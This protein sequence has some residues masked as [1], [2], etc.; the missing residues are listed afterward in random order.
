MKK[1]LI[2]IIFITA[3]LFADYTKVTP[4]IG[5]VPIMD[6]PFLAEKYYEHYSSSKGFHNYRV[7]IDSR[8]SYLKRDFFAKA[9]GVLGEENIIRVRKVSDNVETIQVSFYN[10]E[11]RQGGKG[12][13]HVSAVHQ[14]L[15]EEAAESKAPEIKKDPIVKIPLKKAIFDKFKL[16]YNIVTK[17]DLEDFFNED[18]PGFKEEIARIKASKSNPEDKA[19]IKK[20]STNL[21]DLQIELDETKENLESKAAKLETAEEE[22][23]SFEEEQ[24]KEKIKSMAIAGAVALIIGLVIGFSLKKS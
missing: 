14:K 2:S 3:S 9:L 12:F 10:T 21:E 13:V 19:K 1:L 16:E 6:S 23:K 8:T 20:L 7:R 15:V 4:A 5:K 24:K 22:L 18:L 17:G 11:T